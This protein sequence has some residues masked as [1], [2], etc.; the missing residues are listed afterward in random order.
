M[1]KHTVRELI[2]LL[3]LYESL[4]TLGGLPLRSYLQDG[5]NICPLG[6]L[7]QFPLLAF[8]AGHTYRG[9]VRRNAKEEVIMG[10]YESSEKQFF[11]EKPVPW[12]EIMWE[13]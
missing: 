5:I 10:D 12:K 6:D 1:E 2:L 13:K 8:A 9:Q 4:L 11:M 3:F 7:R